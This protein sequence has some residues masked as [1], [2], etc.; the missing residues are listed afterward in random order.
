MGGGLGPVRFARPAQTLAQVLATEIS[1]ELVPG[2]SPRQPGQLS[3]S[4]IGPYA[5]QDFT[6]YYVLRFGY[7]P[8]KVAFLAWSAWKDEYRSR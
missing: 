6:L 3:E 2:K 4:M 1:P 5:L 7:A 8:A